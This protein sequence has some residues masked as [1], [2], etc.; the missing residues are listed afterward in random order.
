MRR[1]TVST[2]RRQNRSLYQSSYSEVPYIRLAGNW[3]S[4]TGI[5]AGEKV[6]VHP[7]PHGLWITKPAVINEG[8]AR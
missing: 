5:A 3:L 8:S 1:L 2:L 7:M 4:Q 6:H